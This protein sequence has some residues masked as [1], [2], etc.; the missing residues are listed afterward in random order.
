MQPGI[1]ILLPRVEKPARYLGGETGAAPPPGPGDLRFVLCFPDV[2]EIGMSHRGLLNL[3]AVLA[4]AEGVA[5]ERCFAPWPDMAAELRGRGLPL[6]SLESGLPLARADALG[7]SFASPLHF[8]TALMMLEL[9]GVPALARERGEEAPLVVAGGQAMFNPEPMA[10]FLDAVAPGEG[11]EVILE[12][13]RV[14]RGARAERLSRA[15]TLRRL[16]ALAGVYIPAWYEA[17]YEEGRFASLR[18]EAFAPERIRK[19]VLADAGEIPAAPALVA[20]VPPAHDRPAVEVMRGCK[21]GCRFCQAGMVTRPPRERD[22]AA[23]RREAET[24]VRESGAAELS[25]LALN[26]CDYSALDRLVDNVRAA[27]PD[28]KLSLPAARIST[29]RDDVA[30][31]L[32][33]QRR[34][35]QTLAPEV[36]AERLRAVINKEFTNDDVLAAVAAAG[37]AG[38]Q[39]VKLYFMVGLPG[40]TDEDAAAIGDLLA[41]CRRALRDGL[42][43]WGN[44]S[45]AI[46]PFVPQ[47]HTPFQW[48]GMAPPETI[49]RRLALAK[50]KAPRRVKVEGSA[51]TRLLEAALARGDRRLGAV[52]REAQRRGARLDAW[53]EHYDE[54]AWA[55]AFA[56]AGLDMEAYATRELPLDAPLPWD[57]VDV[58]VAKNYLRAEYEKALAGLT[59]P[60]CESEACRR[61]G[62]CGEELTV[63]RADASLPPARPAVAASRM[64]RAQRLLFT[65]AKTGRWR[66]LSHLELYRLLLAQL[67]RS[68]LPLSWSAGYSPKPR[69]SLAPALAV[70]V[71][72]EAEFGEAV[73]REE[74]A[75]DDFVARV[76]A[77]GPF[78]VAAARLV[79]A[80]A[81]SLE[82]RVG[83]A[84]YRLEFGPV[85][86]SLGVAAEALARTVDVKLRETAFR[87][88]TRRGVRD[89]AGEVEVR[90][91]DPAAGVLELDVEATATGAVFDLVAHLAEV[92][93]SE[94]RAARVTRT[95]AFLADEPAPGRGGVEPFFFASRRRN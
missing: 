22:A 9:A 32:V 18:R 13:A 21:W 65:Y 73:L 8:T 76:N 27:F 45:A 74:V 89:L 44:L 63:A 94:S 55:A 78:P 72:G 15:E 93:S 85:A 59:S 67:R 61:C 41:A 95:R 6:V 36:G 14:L 83:G 29:Y 57:H 82:R 49:R 53:G 38:C 81:Q 77:E 50:A 12:I 91:W 54:E 11:E 1:E 23:C 58:G 80:G 87:V 71:A 64:E 26:A 48:R 3:Y 90:S 39:N 52:V 4:A 70:G 47:A 7:F 30:A 75:P 42:G 62:A 33:S 60:P 35:Q 92:S 25:F 88:P 56:E 51:G 19:R 5:P 10:D 66:W 31:A 28:V 69:L 46:A 68:G 40:E 24:L 84:R 2:Y 17:E 16:G 86:E 37:R 20:N 43:R 34:S 79:P